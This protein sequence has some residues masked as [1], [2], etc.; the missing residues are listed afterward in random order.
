MEPPEGAD[1][2]PIWR[3]VVAVLPTKVK[4]SGLEGEILGAHIT[5]GGGA[6]SIASTLEELELGKVLALI[7]TLRVNLKDRICGCAMIRKCSSGGST[8]KQ[9]FNQP[10]LSLKQ[11][12]ILRSLRHHLEAPSDEM[13][14]KSS[15]EICCI[16]SP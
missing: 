8:H 15:E 2:D 9:E 3:V 1:N 11:Q 16:C 10:L 7:H 4:Q 6:I 12:L 5:L 14:A 13:G